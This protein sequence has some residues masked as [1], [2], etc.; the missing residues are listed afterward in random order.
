GLQAKIFW[1]NFQLFGGLV[2]ALGTLVFALRYT[3]CQFSNPKRAWSLLTIIP[4]TYILLAYTDGWHGL[5]H[6]EA[7]LIPGEPFSELSYDFTLSTWVIFIYFA[8]LLLISVYTLV[9]AFVNASS[10]YRKQVG[11]IV[12]GALIPLIGLYLTI[13]GVTLSFHRDTTPLTFA[14]GNLLIAWGLFRFRLFDVVPVARDTV[15]ENMRDMLIVL[16]AQD[17]VVDLNK[18][19]RKALLGQ[20]SASV[21]GQPAREI[22]STWPS[23]MKRYQDIEEARAEISNGEGENQAFFELDIS[24]L[25]DHNGKFHGRLILIHE[26]TERVRAERDL[27]A[28]N[29]ELEAFAYSVSHDLRAPLRA[30][31]GYS[32]ALLEDYGATLN[33]MGKA[34]LQYI[35]ESSQHMSQLIDALLKLSRV[36]HSEVNRTQV[37]LSA[38]AAEIARGLQKDQPERQVE[39]VI[40]ESMLVDADPKLT[41]IVMQNL[42]DNAWKFTSK[43]PT[44]SIEVGMIEEPG[45]ATVYFVRD[46]G[47]GFNMTYIE[48]LFNP[49][50]RLHGAHEFKGSGI[51]LATAQR[52]I[53]RHN[54]HIW[55]KGA[56][57]QG[58]TFYFTL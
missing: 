4:A 48:K 35:C 15:I 25:R 19:A 12:I 13:M 18:A 10:L 42:L 27:K 22:F 28:A 17:R 53:K 33:D 8:V 45:Q 7:W 50:Q 49:F 29:Q 2:Y 58:A 38:M 57:E 1:D 3:G 31:D 5:I 52:I 40:H 44:A 24:C 56:V 20:S 6:P 14:L 36:M 55:A 37:D 26:I 47:A 41:R 39:F 30:I 34:Y 11:L 32:Q 46:N 43:N 16:D 23:L 54:G 51:G 9:S 21:I